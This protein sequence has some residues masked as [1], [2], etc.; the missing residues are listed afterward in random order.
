MPWEVEHPSADAAMRQLPSHAQPPCRHPADSDCLAK[1]PLVDSRFANRFIHFASLIV[2]YRV[3]FVQTKSDLLVW[4][5]SFAG[6]FRDEPG[7]LP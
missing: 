1:I 6:A 2:D 7:D 4:T 3:G 5:P